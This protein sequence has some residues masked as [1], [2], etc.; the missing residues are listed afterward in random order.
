MFVKC[1]SSNREKWMVAYFSISVRFTAKFELNFV[2]HAFFY[3]Q[4]FF[5]TQSPCCLTFSW[6]QLEMLLHVIVLRH[7]LYLVYLCL[8]LGLGQFMS[9][10][11]DLSFYFEPHFYC[12]KLY[13]VIKTDT[14]AFCAF[15]RMS[16]I[17]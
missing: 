3:K 2:L 14:L 12:H 6:I 10:L 15:F 13:N 5:S 11:C 17:V 4:R 1:D 16:P 7:I 9:Y 8:C